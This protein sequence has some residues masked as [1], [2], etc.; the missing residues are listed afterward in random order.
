MT[1]HVCS[2][3]DLCLTI[4]VARVSRLLPHAPPARLKTSLA[5][6]VAECSVAAGAPAA[7]PPRA[8]WL[9]PPQRAPPRGDWPGLTK[10]PA[11]EVEVACP[12]VCTAGC[13]M[14]FA[15]PAGCGRGE[16]P[17]P[18]AGLWMDG[19]AQGGAT[20]DELRRALPAAAAD[21]TSPGFVSPGRVS[22][23]FVCPVCP[24]FVSPGSVGPG[25]ICRAF[26]RGGGGMRVVS[27]SA[28]RDSRDGEI[29][30]RPSEMRSRPNEIQVRDGEI[31]SRAGEVR[32]RPAEA[33][34]S[35]RRASGRSHRS[36]TE[37]AVGRKSTH[38]GRA[39]PPR[40]R[41]LPAPGPGLFWS[42]GPFSSAGLFGSWGRL[43]C[44][45]GLFWSA[46]L[47]GSARLFWSAYPTLSAGRFGP[48]RLF[49]S[50]GQFRSPCL[51]LPAGGSC[52]VAAGGV[53]GAG[54]TA[55]GALGGDVTLQRTP[56]QQSELRGEGRGG[57]SKN[58][59]PPAACVAAPASPD[60]AAP[61]SPAASPANRPPVPT[62]P[63]RAPR[64]PPPPPAHRPCKPAG[65]PA[66]A[67]H[68][69][70]RSTNRNSRVS[71][72]EAESSSPRAAGCGTRLHP[73]PGSAP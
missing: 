26:V 62:S 6:V 63:T 60:A 4:C 42:A 37:L 51:F 39:T 30:C 65:A 1:S 18:R 22:A 3:R 53:G 27:R 44:S 38:A 56:D 33:L 10:S 66:V 64:V 59:S 7:A 8:L 34:L 31:A 68:C 40:T 55:W 11:A 67:R 50:I 15:H 14:G 70:C 73:S 48:D 47:F 57:Q 24:G 45:D 49:R 41:R 71:A 17:R 61:P 28:G 16:A 36:V 43:C 23:G 35:R 69:A 52:T 72:T 58:R 25:F 32:S 9:L 5:L 12:R 29:P 21:G 19:A 2:C 20:S 46:G 54:A 13:A